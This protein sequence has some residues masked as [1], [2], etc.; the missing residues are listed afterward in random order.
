MRSR[1]AG[2]EKGLRW[3]VNSIVHDIILS[4]KW[5]VWECRCIDES[6]CFILEIMCG[7]WPSGFKKVSIKNLHTSITPSWRANFLQ[8]LW[9]SPANRQYSWHNWLSCRCS[10]LAAYHETANVTESVVPVLMGNH[11]WAQSLSNPQFFS[12]FRAIEP[13]NGS[14]IDGRDCSINRM[15]VSSTELIG[16]SPAFAMNLNASAS[17]L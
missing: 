7:N 13:L 9:K 5:L 1:T 17:E 15:C 3:S 14:A 11:R 2:R 6:C 10:S 16:F 4:W 8:C 12:R